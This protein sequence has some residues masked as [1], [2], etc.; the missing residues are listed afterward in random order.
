M[1]SEEE[2]EFIED[3][4]KDIDEFDR[5]EDIYMD[6]PKFEKDLKGDKIKFINGEHKGKKV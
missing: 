5:F 1:T 6:I 3:E 2:Q 4:I